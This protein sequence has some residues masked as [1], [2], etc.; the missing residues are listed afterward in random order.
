MA[1]KDKEDQTLGFISIDD[2][3]PNILRL[4][5][6]EEITIIDNKQYVSKEVFDNIVL[7][8]IDNVDENVLPDGTVYDE[9]EM[10][11]EEYE[12]AIMEDDDGDNDWSNDN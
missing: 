12:D 11:L 1:K 6:M 8:D 9:F 5:S 7:T 4:I 3:L 10:Y 2:I